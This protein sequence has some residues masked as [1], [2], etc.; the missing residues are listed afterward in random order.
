M[1]TTPIVLCISGNNNMK[2]LSVWVWGKLT[3]FNSNNYYKNYFIFLINFLL[4]LLFLL[5]YYYQYLYIY[6]FSSFFPFFPFSP[7]FFNFLNIFLNKPILNRFIYFIFIFYL[8]HWILILIFFHP[9]DK[10]TNWTF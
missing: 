3:Y 6:D 8:F 10:I 4:K 1:N 7:I 9:K 2:A 5:S